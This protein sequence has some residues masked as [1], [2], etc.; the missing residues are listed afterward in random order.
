VGG[1]YKTWRIS[2]TVLEHIEKSENGKRRQRHMLV[3]LCRWPRLCSLPE[4][5]IGN[6]YAFVGSNRLIVFVPCILDRQYI[7]MYVVMSS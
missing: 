6:I 3:K 2:V 5:Y 4:I 1:T 7:I